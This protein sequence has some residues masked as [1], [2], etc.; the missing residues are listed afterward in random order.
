MC[1]LQVVKLRPA[2][3][4]ITEYATQKEAEIRF[5]KDELL[6]REVEFE[7]RV[8]AAIRASKL[9]NEQD[10]ARKDL[11][12]SED[13]RCPYVPTNSNDPSDYHRCENFVGIHHTEDP[14]T[15]HAQMFAHFDFKSITRSLQFESSDAH[16]WHHSSNTIGM[17]DKQR[18]GVG[19]I[20][21]LRPSCF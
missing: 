9:S 15:G 5:V 20:K 10:V 6:L 11:I 12:K 13:F 3:W 8:A 17:D 21:P 19:R 14:M 1:A 16:V 18:R 2:E 4:K 7:H